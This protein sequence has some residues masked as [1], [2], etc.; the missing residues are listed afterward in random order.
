MRVLVTGGTG[1]VAGWCI[2]ELLRQGHDV[3]TTVRGPASE[4]RVRAAVGDSERLTVVAADLLADAGWAQAMAGVERVLHVA[5]PMTGA[6]MITPARDGTVRVLH[7]A[8]D[9]GVPH[10][11]MTSSCAAATPPP[12]AEGEFDES[13][14]TDPDQAGLDD[15]RRSK[16]VAE[17]AAWAA[18]AGGPTTLT[19]VL[20]GAV[21]GPVRS[22][23]GLRSVQV[24]GRMLRGMPGVP[25][26]GLNVVDVRD[27]ADL[28]I[29]AMTAPEAVGE[30]FIAV[31][32]FLWMS[33]VAAE[34]RDRL[35]DRAARVP[36]RTLPD[37]ALRALARVSPELRGVVPM[38]GRRYVHTSAK[39]RTVL[40]WAPRPATETVVACAESLLDRG[41]G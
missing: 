4:A 14:W 15:Y 38:L 26:I 41:A 36:R 13:V 40:G 5:S 34:I 2:T 19:T 35:G 12:G 33:E 7:A 39:A 22:P 10:V 9:A 31:G 16:L 21:F 30:R 17:R 8:R 27:V 1:F 11:V 25:R 18:V 24:I 3:R 29:R 37:L 6:D 28:H 20:P 23:D 32:G